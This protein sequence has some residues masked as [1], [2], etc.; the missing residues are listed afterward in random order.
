[1]R[2]VSI[3]NT[4]MAYVLVFLCSSLFF[5]SCDVHE[6]PNPPAKV[7]FTLHLYHKTQLPIYQELNYTTQT[8]GDNDPATYD[9]RYII[10]VYR[11]SDGESFTRQAD[12]TIVYTRKLSEE[13]DHSIQLNLSEG[14]YQF[15]VWN[16]YVTKGTKED[17]YYNTSDF[18]E[19][20]YSDRKNYVGNTNFRDAFRG[21][22]QAAV[23]YTQDLRGDEVSQEAAIQLE[24]PLAKFKFIS[25][26][27]EEFVAQVIANSKPKSREASR[28]VN[29]EDYVVVFRYEGYM[30]CSFNMFTNKPNDSWTGMYFN[31]QMAPLGGNE[32]ELGFDY[33]FV[34]GTESRTRVSVEVYDKEGEMLSRTNPMDVP[35]VRS[36]LTIVRGNFLTQKATGSVGINPDFNGDFNIEI[37]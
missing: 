31:G 9:M 24:R 15:M 30:P 6:F 16:D 37:N 29:P 21:N 2:R 1:M 11:S 17:K 14:L 28:T 12:T 4:A 33:V 19:I 10:N 7:P 20:V 36:K 13:Q 27:L 26:D 18:A 3:R 34:N 22:V 35:M 23:A 25:T 5:A 8:R 32:M